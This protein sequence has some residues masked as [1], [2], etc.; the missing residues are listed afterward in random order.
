MTPQATEQDAPAVRSGR[1]ERGTT[2]ILVIFV[3]FVIGTIL[4]EVGL[5]SQTEARFASVN[6]NST[7]ALNLA[8][9]GAQEAIKRLQMFGYTAGVT[10]SSFTNSLATTAG[11]TGTVY[12][13]HTEASNSSLL[14]ILSTATF[15]G[16]T[17]S[18]RVMVN[19][20]PNPWEYQL[21]GYIVNFDGD[22]NP[23][24]ANDLY[25]S[26]DIEFENWP[27]SP[28]CA[29]GATA[30]NLISPQV[31]AGTIVYAESPAANYTPPCGGPT[32]AGTY[33]AECAD[34][35]TY[36]VPI[37]T[38]GSPSGSIPTSTGTHTSAM[39]EVAPTSCA[40]DGGRATSNTAG[41][42]T[43]Q[44]LSGSFTLPVNWH[45][46]VPQ[47]MPQTD[48]TTVIN[49]WN[50]N[51][52]N[53]LSGLTVTQATQTNAAGTQTL[54]TYS[55]N[56]YTPT[57]WA[58]TGTN[59]E[60]LVLGAT[61]AFCVNST[62]HTITAASTSSP[63]CA[64]GSNY[65]GYN[66]N[67]NSTSGGSSDDT[68]AFPTRYIDW[69]LVSDD[70]NRGVPQTFF[71][72]GN[73]N[74]IRYVPVYPDLN[75][76]S[77]SCQQT[78][79]PGTNVYD[80]LNGGPACSNPAITTISSTNVTFSGTQ[81][82]PEA[83]IIDN[84]TGGTQVVTITGS[85]GGPSSGTSCS[86]PNFNTGNWGVILATGDLALAGNLEFSGFIYAQGNITTSGSSSQHVWLQGGIMSQMTSPPQNAGIMDLNNTSSFIGLCG[87]LPPTLGSPIFSTYAPLTWVDV[88][89]NQP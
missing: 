57:Y 75:V 68:G 69:G 87:G 48:F 82:N 10:S 18:V 58:T 16:V 31:M 23:T 66:G 39:G 73:Q 40:K 44:S 26:A 50:G 34:L 72:T 7:E 88:P 49:K 64:A 52:A 24:S 3:M 33:F 63:Y 6:R 36:F 81:S 85:L 56:T 42:M 46:M 78:M 74:G 59:G 27:F 55:P 79:N 28:L 29:S 20:A 30:T 12:F 51:N 53:L 86:T 13:Q 80:N 9:A 4:F 15:G 8:E 14:P 25:A 17:R 83:L 76:L 45:P 19:A 89:L 70:I 47:G 71:G 41:G 77:Y 84:K 60:V 61:K 43:T 1:A 62:T 67:I 54:V 38:G 21:Y 35:Q 5:T 11:G 32:N 65:Y 37:Q 2:L 22:T